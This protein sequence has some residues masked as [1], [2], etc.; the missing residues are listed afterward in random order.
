M[1]GSG[2]LDF[3]MLKPSLLK[4]FACPDFLLYF[5]QERLVQNSNLGAAAA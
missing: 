3:G 2:G 1:A 5:E 4:E